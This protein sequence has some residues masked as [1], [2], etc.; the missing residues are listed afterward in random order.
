M[1]TL[2]IDEETLL[3][4]LIDR[5][6]YWTDDEDTLELFN[7][8]YENQVYNGC[9]EGANF[10][11]MSIVDNDYVNNLTITD[12]AEFEKARE[13]YITENNITEEDLE[14]VP[15]WDDIEVGENNIKFLSGYYIEAK[16]EDALLIS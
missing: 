10:D 13:E 16:T 8:Y 15:T 3:E 12:R 1:V 6:K 9:F 5:V 7:Q 14:D 11:V 2:N 4:L